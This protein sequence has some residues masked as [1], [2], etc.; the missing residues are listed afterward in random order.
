VVNLDVSQQISRRLAIRII[1]ALILIFLLLV[2]TN[3][4]AGDWY[5]LKEKAPSAISKD[6]YHKISRFSD[7][8]DKEALE[9]L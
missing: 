8:G 9:K 1:K 6:L 2:S 5:V 7:Q 4:F 3:I